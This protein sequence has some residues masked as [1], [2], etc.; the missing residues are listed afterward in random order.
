M[1][2]LIR[3]LGSAIV[4]AIVAYFALTVPLGK[5]T[6]WGHLCAI[7]GS[8]EAKDLAD[9]AKDV[10]KDAVDRASKELNK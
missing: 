9:G 2:K 1:F 5:R 10:A 8:P 4:F 7:V 6:L 3:L